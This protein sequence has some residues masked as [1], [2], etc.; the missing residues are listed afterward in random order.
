[1][2]R[3]LDAKPAPVTV[4]MCL[5]GVRRSTWG[6]FECIQRSEQ[7]EDT[8]CLIV[9]VVCGLAYIVFD[10]FSRHAQDVQQLSEV[11]DAVPQSDSVNGFT[12]SLRV[13]A[14]MRSSEGHR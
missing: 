4:T 5:F 11:R 14:D 7:D 13:C 8:I 1:M 9:Y 3:N 6:G 12:R 10:R 2:P